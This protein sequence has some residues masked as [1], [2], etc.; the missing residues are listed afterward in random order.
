MTPEEMEQL[1][2]DLNQQSIMAES[3]EIEQGGMFGPDT[4]VEIGSKALPR[5]QSNRSLP[6]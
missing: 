4:V 5:E 1:L 3:G 6:V 2:A